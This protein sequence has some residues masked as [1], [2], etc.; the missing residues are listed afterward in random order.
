MTCDVFYR[1]IF[2]FEPD[3]GILAQ[4]NL[5]TL[6]TINRSHLCGLVRLQVSGM[7]RSQNGLS[8]ADPFFERMMN[9]RIATLRAFLRMATE[10]YQ[11]PEPSTT[12]ENSTGVDEPIPTDS[13][14]IEL[15]LK[16]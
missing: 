9:E 2:A 10:K 16:R 8:T 14:V 1:G 15:R 13:N 5:K 4:I 7:N 6:L 12:T 3:I 11:S